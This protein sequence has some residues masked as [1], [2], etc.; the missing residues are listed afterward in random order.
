MERVDDEEF[1]KLYMVKKFFQIPLVRDRGFEI[2]ENDKNILSKDFLFIDFMNFY[3][4][5]TNIEKLY[6]KCNNEYYSKNPRTQII[7]DDKTNKNRH[8]LV[9]FLYES[10]Q[11]I[12]KN[13]LDK[14]VEKATINMEVYSEIILLT[15]K[16]LRA[17]HNDL[18]SKLTW[19]RI[20]IFLI[21][22]VTFN[23]P[24]HALASK[25]R[26][27]SDEER[28]E[29]IDEIVKSDPLVKNIN[30]KLPRMAITDII[31]MYYGWN[32]DDIIEIT[33]DVRTD[34]IAD[35]KL[36]YRIVR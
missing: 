23:P 18:L 24:T 8:I 22:E 20:D 5:E 35:T 15:N 26:K 6:K 30:T 1:Y 19:T 17:Q 32:Q 11:N 14:F 36:E 3:D 4:N 29:F 33:R 21:D 25:C 28:K 16:S 31:T 2:T 13:N 34:S 12:S 27:L 10:G 9:Y 7:P